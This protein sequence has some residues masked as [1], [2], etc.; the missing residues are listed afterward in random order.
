MRSRRLSRGESE[1]REGGDD[2][3]AALPPS[4]KTTT[5]NATSMPLPQSSSPPAPSGELVAPANKPAAPHGLALS[6][7]EAAENEDNDLDELNAGEEEEAEE[8]R[9]LNAAADD[10]NAANAADAAPPPPS[11]SDTRDPLDHTK[12]RGVQL[13]YRRSSASSSSSSTS[14]SAAVTSHPLLFTAKARWKRREV[15]VGTAHPTAAAAAVARDRA[16]FALAGR[17]DLLRGA[18]KKARRGPDRL[19]FPA[20][21]YPEAE[22]RLRAAGAE[23][24]AFL[25]SLR[26]GAT[27]ARGGP[28]LLESRARRCGQCATCARPWLK[29]R[30]LVGGGKAMTTA[31][32]TTTT[33][34]AA[35]RRPLS[36]QKRRAAR[37][38]QPQPQQLLPPPH[39]LSA[40]KVAQ[41]EAELRAEAAA[42]A[43]LLSAERGGGGG[44]GGGDGTVF[45]GGDISDSDGSFFYRS[46][47]SPSLQPGMGIIGMQEKQQQQQQQQELAAVAAFSSRGGGGGEKRGNNGTSF[48]FRAFLN[49]AKKSSDAKRNGRFSF[50]ALPRA[51][52]HAPK[53]CALCREVGAHHAGGSGLCPLMRLLLEEEGGGEEGEKEGGGG[54]RGGESDNA[55]AA[56]A[57]TAATPSSSLPEAVAALAAAVR[58]A[59]GGGCSSK[60]R[61]KF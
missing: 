53:R 40:T 48:D 56:A 51:G 22:N 4:K 12:F 26:A 3:A 33:P 55:A 44:G 43:A 31:T 19:N 61:K 9:A 49:K 39:P 1:G 14:T 41:R 13:T 28:A 36:A 58:L 45:G 46:S 6:L 5:A 16:L 57:A 23:L 10:L 7:A 37:S 52:A 11:S 24:E 32:A 29:K 47:R 27:P 54:R 35:A 50:V 38:P 60:K 18:G 34:A 15:V 59:A 17:Q 25:R 20:S 42:T 30:C 21:N 2:G 8:E